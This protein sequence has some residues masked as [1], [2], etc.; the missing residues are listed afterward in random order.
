[1]P[2]LS[3]NHRV[4]T[5]GETPAATPASSLVRPLAIAAQ[6]RLPMLSTG[7][8][9]TTWRSHSGSQCPIRLPPLGLLHRNSLLQCCEDPLHPVCTPP[10][11]TRSDWKRSALRSVGSRGDSYDKTY[12][13]YCTSF[14]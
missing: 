12:A 1:M 8:R 14:R 9:R 3:R 7:H 4:P 11:A 5:T 10:S 13:A 6:N 2:P